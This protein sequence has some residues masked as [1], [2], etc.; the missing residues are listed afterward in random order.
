MSESLAAGHWLIT[1]NRDWLVYLLRAPCK[2]TQN[3]R[4]ETGRLLDIGRLLEH[5]GLSI[6]PVTALRLNLKLPTVLLI[7]AIIT[8]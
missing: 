8:G 7:D 3:Y 2:Y 6:F 5:V 1:P 4:F